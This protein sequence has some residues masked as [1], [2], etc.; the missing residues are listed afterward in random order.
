MKNWMKNDQV[1]P[2]KCLCAKVT[3]DV[4]LKIKKDKNWMKNNEVMLI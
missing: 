2:I 3:S 4:I 1:M